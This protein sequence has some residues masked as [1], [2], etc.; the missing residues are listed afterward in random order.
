[1]A[2]E[3]GIAKDGHPS[4]RCRDNAA[5]YRRFVVVEFDQPGDEDLQPALHWHLRELAP[6]VMCVESGGKSIH[7][8]YYV[9]PQPDE[10]QM[11][12]FRHAVSIGADSKMWWPEQLSRMPNG[13]RRNERGEIVA[14][15]RV[16]YLNLDYMSEQKEVWHAEVC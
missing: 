2:A 1:M 4:F 6:L 15:Q 9:E 13:V 14:A 8:W 3:E 5:Q 10:W 12:F 7:G 11:R 16:I